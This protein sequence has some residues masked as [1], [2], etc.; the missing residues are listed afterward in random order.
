MASSNWQ[1]QKFDFLKDF[2][3]RNCISFKDVFFVISLRFFA[4]YLDVP[5]FI[6][7]CLMKLKRTRIPIHLTYIYLTRHRPPVCAEN[8]Q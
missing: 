6:N 5:Y 7:V 8:Q 1:N 2:S 4:T 3:G